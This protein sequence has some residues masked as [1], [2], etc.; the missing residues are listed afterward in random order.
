MIFFIWKK[1]KRKKWSKWV[2][3]DVLVHI[4]SYEMLSLPS[5]L[6]LSAPP[7]YIFAYVCVHILKPFVRCTSVWRWLYAM[8]LLILWLRI[9]ILCACVCRI[10]FSSHIEWCWFKFSYMNII[11]FSC[12][13][14]RKTNYYIHSTLYI[15][16][17]IVFLRAGSEIIGFHLFLRDGQIHRPINVSRS[18]RIFTVFR[19]DGHFIWHFNYVS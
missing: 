3:Y 6:N 17:S 2:M 8:L 19:T 9:A 14:K 12:R 11:C 1:E 4:L 13:R 15:I 10:I 16:C 7:F 18:N 5:M